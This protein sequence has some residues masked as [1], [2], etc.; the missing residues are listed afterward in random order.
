MKILIWG[1]GQLAGH[2]VR[3]FD[4][5]NIAGYIDSNKTP[6]IF[7]DK[8]LYRPIDL[9]TVEYDAIVVATI[10][11]KEIADSCKELGIPLEKVIFAYGNVLAKDLNK[12]YGFV[13]R[14]CGD[15]YG[16]VIQKRYHMIPETDTGAEKPDN[17]FS[18][19]EYQH[20]QKYRHDYVRVKTLELLCDEIK[21]NNIQGEIAELGVFRG[22][23]AMFLNAAFPNRKL[24]L[25]DTFEGFDQEELKRE[26]SGEHLLADR[27]AF[28]NTSADF[29]IGRMKYPKNVIIKQGLFPDSLDGLEEEFALVSLDCDWEESIYQGLEYFV[30][31]CPRG[32]YIML[33]DYNNFIGVSVKRAIAR[34]ESK[35]GKKLIKVPICDAQGSVVL[36][37]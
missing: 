5:V 14:I 35:I 15:R 26:T 6:G 8:P 2:V 22:E 19:D 1:T 28:T 34:F 20:E 3:N 4:S 37:K 18:I 10:Y 12:D 31:R 16:E 9:E 24:Y 17:A 13:K 7:A 25:F 29:V 21:S 30:P 23:F 27:D 33:H 11:A 32:G 36:A